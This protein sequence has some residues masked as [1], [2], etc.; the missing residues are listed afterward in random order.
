MT[1]RTPKN[2]TSWPKDQGKLWCKVED[3]YGRTFECLI[4]NNLLMFDNQ[5]E[6]DIITDDGRSTTKLY[7]EG[8]RKIEVI[9]VLGARKIG[10]LP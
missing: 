9:G 1:P 7:H 10:G 2:W 4:N 3:I 6:V 8:L 5:T